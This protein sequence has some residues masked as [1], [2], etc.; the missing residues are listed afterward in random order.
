MRRRGPDDIPPLAPREKGGFEGGWW[1]YNGILREVYLRKIVN[2]DMT[3]AL[4]TPRMRCRG[5]PASVT[6]DARVEN[7]TRQGRKANVFGTFGGRPLRFKAQTVR[8]RGSNHLRAKL[9]IPHPRLWEPGH[10]YLYT[11]KL[12]LADQGGDRE[13][14]RHCL[15]ESG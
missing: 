1:N 12:A 9:K 7:V 10:P 2:L 4:V 5:C 13:A 3:S 14:V 8:G 15:A 11:V 6:I